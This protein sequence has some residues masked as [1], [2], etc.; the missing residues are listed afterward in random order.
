MKK[1]V[2][3]NMDVNCIVVPT[4]Q[5]PSLSWL[6]PQDLRLIEFDY[7]VLA[8]KLMYG[9][10]VVE[11]DKESARGLEDWS[12]YM[13]P[14]KQTSVEAAVRLVLH[15]QRVRKSKAPE[16]FSD[17]LAKVYR[18]KTRGCKVRAR[19][20]AVSD[21]FDAIKIQEGEGEEPLC[22]VEK[23]RKRLSGKLWRRMHS[24]LSNGRTA[25]KSNEP[26]KTEQECLPIPKNVS[27]F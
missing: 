4:D 2:S 3:F 18:I 27:V 7:R 5:E 9:R 10:A 20:R 14:A 21:E 6:Q 13:G 12:P 17:R 26:H 1:S 15:E 11:S 24:L 16:D 19:D 23:K 25:V 8:T 22:K